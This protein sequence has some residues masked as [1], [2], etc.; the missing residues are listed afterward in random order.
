MIDNLMTKA[1][2]ARICNVS[3][4][5][6]AK[7]ATQ[8]VVVLVDG[9]IDVVAS[10]RQMAAFRR[11]GV[12]KGLRDYLESDGERIDS[13]DEPSGHADRHVVDRVAAYRR[14]DLVARLI[15][16]DWKGRCPADEAG[17]DIRLH[18]AAAAVGFELAES[19]QRD[20]GHWGGYQLRS[21]ELIKRHGGL[22]FDVIAAGYG[23]EL[24]AVDV[25]TQCREVLIH[26][27]GGDADDDLFFLDIELLPVLAYPFWPGQRPPAAEGSSR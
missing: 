19:S 15:A 4:P 6:V 10:A 12:P 23:F 22:C 20:D 25:L 24:D 7:W 18:A 5:A 17:E 3:K 26:P 11:D 1:A 16:L 14:D 8:G 9:K 27:D 2:F 21:I 13:A